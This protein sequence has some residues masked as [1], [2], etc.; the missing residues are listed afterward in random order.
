MLRPLVGLTH[1]L[2]SNNQDKHKNNGL[3]AERVAAKHEGLS[4][5]RFGNCSD[6][7]QNSKQDLLLTFSAAAAM[8]KV[9]AGAARFFALS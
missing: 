4:N 3:I 9:S 1:R 2:R 7:I 8:L 5:S 6:Q